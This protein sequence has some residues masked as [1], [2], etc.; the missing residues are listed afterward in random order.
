MRMSRRTVVGWMAAGVV[1]TAIVG[2]A[3]AGGVNVRTPIGAHLAAGATTGPQV[4][5]RFDPA[6]RVILSN[7]AGLPPAS[8]L[9]SQATRG[10]RL[11]LQRCSNCHR[12]AQFVGQEFVESWNDRRVYDFYAL[13]RA[14]MPLNDPG[15]LKDNEYLDLVAY[16]LG[17]NHASPG[18]DSLKA[19]TTA[20]RGTRISVR[21]P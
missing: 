3:S 5:L 8:F 9:S 19:D 14:T 15:G 16:V 17:A 7:A 18:T 20:L 13:V 6:A 2:C 10:E 11:Y 1:S 4:P 12:A 21:F